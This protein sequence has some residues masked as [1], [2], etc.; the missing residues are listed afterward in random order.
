MW[1]QGAMEWRTW[2]AFFVASWVISLSPGPGALSCMTSGMRYGYRTAIW[3]IFGLQAGILTLVAIVALGLGALLT[4]SVVAFT[5][6]KWLGA[7]YLV[8]LGVQQ[9]RAPARPF[10]GDAS[11]EEGGRPRELFIRGYLV[12]VTNPKGIVFLLAVLP[13]FIDP[14]VPT[15]PQYAAC[16]ATILFTDVVVMSGYTAIAG[17]A[18][19]WMRGEHNLRLL[20][21]CFGTLFVAA[22]AFLA[23]Y[24]HA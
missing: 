23:V 15:L 12:N 4:A 19:R 14:R 10:T 8:Y 13:Q 24:K 1:F 9:W 2:L 6:V 5:A 22:G 20:N 17:T 21:R 16:C 3:N 7:A 18:L 11:L